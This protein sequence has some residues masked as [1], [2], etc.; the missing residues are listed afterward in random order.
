MLDDVV[1]ILRL[2]Q[3]NIKAS[4]GVDAANGSRVGATLVD[5]DLLGQTV[6][7]DGALQVAPRRNRCKVLRNWASVV[8]GL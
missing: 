8:S 5:R 7:I 1:Q 2:P 4:V 3:L 6:Q